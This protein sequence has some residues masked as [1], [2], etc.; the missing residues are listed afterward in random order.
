MPNA[1]TESRKLYVAN[2]TKQDSDFAYRTTR[3]GKLIMQ[4]IHVGRQVKLAG[5]LTGA[6]IAYIIDQHAKYGFV[7][8][9]DIDRTKPFIG[10][11]YDDKPIQ[12]DAIRQALAHNDAVLL[13]RG[14]KTR[15]GAAVD[16]HQAVEQQLEGASKLDTLEVAIEEE[17]KDSTEGEVLREEV[18]V[19]TTADEARTESKKPG[20][21]GKGKNRR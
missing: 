21:G 15:E 18:L 20:K 17:K 5:D 2:C 19:D 9:R 13:E 10:L 12:V 7:S 16:T 4:K 8:V 3:G 1:T 11:C 6:E 14:R